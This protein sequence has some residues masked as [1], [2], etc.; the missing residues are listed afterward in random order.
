MTIVFG[1]IFWPFGLIYSLYG[2]KKAMDGE[3]GYPENKKIY[4]VGLIV[5]CV[6]AVIWIVSIIR[7]STMY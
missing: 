4:I 2:L 7:L 6:V 3:K 5:S 1:V